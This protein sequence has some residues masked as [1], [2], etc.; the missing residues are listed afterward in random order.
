MMGEY[1]EE[2][3]GGEARTREIGAR[4]SPGEDR[5]LVESEVQ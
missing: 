5:A 2:G 4:A 1:G 3:E